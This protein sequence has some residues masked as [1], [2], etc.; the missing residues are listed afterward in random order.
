MTGVEK[1]AINGI[2]DDM[3]KDRPSGRDANKPA[4]PLSSYDRAK[5]VIGME[6]VESGIALDPEMGCGTL[7]ITFFDQSQRPLFVSKLCVVSRQ[8]DRGDVVTL[9][10]KQTPVK[11]PA[12]KTAG[13]PP[14]PCTPQIAGGFQ[15]RPSVRATGPKRLRTPCI[16][17]Y[18]GKYPSPMR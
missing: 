4:R 1:N 2:R 13:A 5:A 8:L 3:G 11:L 10:L 15:G 6:K 9:R 14:I 17:P 7:L 18:I 16:C 12:N